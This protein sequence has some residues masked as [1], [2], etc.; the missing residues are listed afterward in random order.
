MLHQILH[1]TMVMACCTVLEYNDTV[2]SQFWLFTVSSQPH[3]IVQ[4]CAVIMATDFH[5][6]W[7]GMVMHK[8]ILAEEHDMHGF[9]STL[10]APCYFFPWQHSGTL[11]SIL[12]F[13]L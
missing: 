7:H 8:S 3:L 6:N 2:L 5:T 10:N 12:S 4:E 11:L 1:S 9:Q 13:E